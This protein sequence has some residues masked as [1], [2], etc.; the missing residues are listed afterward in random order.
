MMP[1][2]YVDNWSVEHVPMDGDFAYMLVSLS[3]ATF[4]A[5]RILGLDAVVERY[6]LGG[7]TLVERYPELRYVLC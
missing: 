6:N 3:L 1:L 4:G 2:F 7:E 5:G